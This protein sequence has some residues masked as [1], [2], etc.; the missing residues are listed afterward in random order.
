[1]T[2]LADH[3]AAVKAA[4]AHIPTIHVVD[5][6][7]PEDEVHVYL[8]VTDEPDAEGCTLPRVQVRFVTPQQCEYPDCR[9]P[10]EEWDEPEGG[11][12]ALPPFDVAMKWAQ[13]AEGRCQCPETLWREAMG[14]NEP[15]E[16]SKEGEE[17]AEPVKILPGWTG[18][19]LEPGEW[20]YVARISDGLTVRRTEDDGANTLDR[21]PSVWEA[22][23]S[24][25]RVVDVVA[26]ETTLIYRPDHPDF[27][28]DG[29]NPRHRCPAP[30]AARTLREAIEEADRRW[31]VGNPNVSNQEGEK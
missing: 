19:E 2:T 14:D 12:A 24:V 16:A 26:M 30:L 7:P 25:D 3:I 20:E 29:R 22:F 1:M 10:G 6:L 15:V 21:A 8:R 4:V 23:P 28:D 31:P 11:R 5:T 13:R 9:L 18:N 27:T 17:E